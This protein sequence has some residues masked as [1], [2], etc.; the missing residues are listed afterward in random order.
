MPARAIA[1]TNY[2]ISKKVRDS[3]VAYSQTQLLGKIERD[4]K[5]LASER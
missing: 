3:A 4:L 2:D 1:S 5:T